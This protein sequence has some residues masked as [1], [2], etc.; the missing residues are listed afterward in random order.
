MLVEFRQYHT[1]A[2]TPSGLLL[3]GGYRVIFFLIVFL[4][5]REGRLKS[6]VEKSTELVSVDGG[7]LISEESFALQPGNV[8]TENH[9]NAK[10]KIFL[11]PLLE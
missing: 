6:K 5:E 11:H 1:A 9:K 10:I 4:T 8:K 7:G 2:V 3:V